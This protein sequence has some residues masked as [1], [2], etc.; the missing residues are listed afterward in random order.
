MGS[1]HFLTE[2]TSFIA[3]KIAEKA[4]LNGQVDD[5]NEIVWLKRQVV[6]NS[7]YGVDIN[8]LA[9]E[10]GK[11]SLWIETMSEGKPLSF[12]DH[13]LKVG[14]SL[15]GT[16]IEEL[17]HHPGIEDRPEADFE[18]IFG[19]QNARDALHLEYK[20]IEH[21]SEETK[22]DVHEKEQAYKEFREENFYY[23]F[24]KKLSN[25]HT[26]LTFEDELSPKE[27]NQIRNEVM[28]IDQHEGESW[29]ESAQGDATNR[30]YFHWEL[31]FPKVFFSTS[32]GFDAVIGNPPYARIQS[33]KKNFPEAAKYYEK[34]YESSTQNFD[35]YANF[36][37]KGYNLLDEEGLLGYIEPHKFFQARFGKGLREFISDRKAIYEITSFEHH[38]VF[39]EASVYTCIL[40]LSGSKHEEFR[41]S[42]VNPEK[43]Q[44]GEKVE[45][46]NLDADYN[47]DSWVFN[48]PVTDSV[49]S[50]IDEAGSTL[51]G[52]TRKIFVGLQTSADKIYLL[53]KIEEPSNG[54]VRVQ[55]QEGN[56]MVLETDLLKPI[57]KGEDVHRYQPL[58][59]NYWVIFPYHIEGDDYDLVEEGELKDEYP[60]TYEY[61]KSN[62]EELRGRENGRM[63]KKG[64]Y[65][66]IYPKN[67]T[68]FDSEKIM[69]P[70]ISHGNNFTYDSGGLYHNTKVYSIA[71]NEETEIS[72]KF[73]LSV[74]NNPLLW[75]FLS[76]TGYTLRG[77]YFTFKTD[78]LNPFSVPKVEFE[79]NEEERSKAVEELKT[80]YNNYL[81]GSE[82]PDTERKDEVLHDFLGFL[83]QQMID[84]NSDL[85]KINLNI[86]DYLGNY[87][88]GDT[89]EEL[90]TQRASG[91]N[92]K[93]VSD[94]AAD[95]EKLQVGAVD[96]ERDGNDV[97]VLVSARF[98]P[99][100]KNVYETD[101]YGYT[102]TELIPT[103][104]F[105]DLSEVEA[106]LIE[107]FVPVA[108]EEAGGFADFRSSA[109]KTMSLIDR[110]KKLTL[111]EPSDVEDELQKFID[112]RD[113]ADEL[114]RKIDRTD[115]LIDEIVYDLYDL[116]EEEIE[117][118]E[119]AI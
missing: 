111:P 61:L 103:L 92:G 109:T 23:K 84:L 48:H 49:L 20:K 22:E 33:L 25:V 66:Y 35:I 67:M 56:E 11:L 9:V 89:L 90:Y 99:E 37:E 27:Y 113:K 60:K 57:L 24:L 8:P 51:E 101:Q 88:E 70:E 12:L 74:L 78:Y 73:L 7:I 46:Y 47:K 58:S 69:T 114:Q 44:K 97:T 96:T 98:K 45:Y 63:D 79:M 77:G 91:L 19:V 21:M 29:Y 82:Q 42:E 26:Y 5:D 53:E 85:D 72:E 87:S 108:V 68:E 62:E 1:G 6:Q 93:P 54:K 55:D 17:E 112:Q 10:L 18:E 75:F 40:I 39:D 30:N 116:T 81:S 105:H 83:S 110:L 32:S 86:R 14:N 102:E 65:A 76:N 36:T 50:K 106:T 31:E 59:P 104:E 80:A 115:I 16:S 107:E 100:N 52:L 94:T 28:D 2:A 119:E 71:L 43:L 3:H 41:Y 15:I 118:V 4:E 13:H 64:W 95:K 117:T 34:K 38:Q